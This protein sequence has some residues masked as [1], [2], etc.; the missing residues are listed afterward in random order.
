MVH[1]VITFN[2]LGSTKF[3]GMRVDKGT[4]FLFNI[5]VSRYLEGFTTLWTSQS[6]A[7][8][9]NVSQPVIQKI[10]M[11]KAVCSYFLKSWQ[12]CANR[13]TIILLLSLGLSL[14]WDLLPT[15]TFWVNIHLYIILL[16]LLYLYYNRLVVNKLERKEILWH[17]TGYQR[18][19]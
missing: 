13:T 19:P 16:F 7:K 1:N 3:T 8:L 4:I 12:D 2:D 17:S 11:L 14:S 15:V 6:Y 10:R 18:G 9:W 5:V